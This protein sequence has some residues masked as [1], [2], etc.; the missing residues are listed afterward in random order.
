M[1]VFRQLTSGL[2]FDKQKFR[3]DAEK[4]GL[5]S[6]SV[7]EKSDSKK[8]AF[9]YISTPDA[10]TSSAQYVALKKCAVNSEPNCWYLKSG[11]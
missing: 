4:F 2:K 6:K 3:N 8:E 9:F 10:A 1:S 11:G 7:A 5:V